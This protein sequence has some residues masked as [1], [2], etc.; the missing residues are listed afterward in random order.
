M[1]TTPSYL[2]GEEAFC[3][4]NVLLHCKTWPSSGFQ[5]SVNVTVEIAADSRGVLGIL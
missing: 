4:I 1:S 3:L 5:L 2:T